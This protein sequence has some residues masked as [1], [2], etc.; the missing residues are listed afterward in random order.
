VEL[1]PR[2]LLIESSLQHKNAYEINMFSIGVR[3]YELE[4]PAKCLVVA[5]STA[6]DES[7]MSDAT[8]SVGNVTG[9]VVN[10][11]I[12][13]NTPHSLLIAGDKL[14]VYVFPRQFQT[15]F[16]IGKATFLDLAG[17]VCTHNEGFFTAAN[18]KTCSEYL[19][20]LTAD[21]NSWDRT[22]NYITQLLAKLYN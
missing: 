8:E 16:S 14:E 18:A 4:Y 6:V 15:D 13:Q 10:Q 20:G 9:M 1:A 17:L 7:T 22:K 21:A 2:R 11:L 5:P 19:Q 3:L 12:E